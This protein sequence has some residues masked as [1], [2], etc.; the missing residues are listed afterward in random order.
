MTTKTELTNG[1]VLQALD[2]TW[3]PRVTGREPG[4]YQG[5]KLVLAG[6][7]DPPDFPNDL[8]AAWK[9]VWSWLYKNW[10]DHPNKPKE[11]AGWN[12]SDMTMQALKSPNPAR[13]FCER[14]IELK[15]EL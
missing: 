14:I 6:N 12:I 15:G 4:W 1:M 7:V 8:N 9:Y 11:F 5:D 10:E 2:W 13:Y 3:E